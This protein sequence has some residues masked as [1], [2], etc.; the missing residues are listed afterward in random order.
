MK[1]LRLAFLVVLGMLATQTIAVANQDLGG[2]H[3]V[4]VAG[5]SGSAAEYPGR[6]QR[7]RAL[8]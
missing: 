5:E 7:S 8:R 1:S 6:G 3:R 2:G 4:V